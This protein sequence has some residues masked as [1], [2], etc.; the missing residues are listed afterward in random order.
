[1]T[2]KTENGELVASKL[3][4][5]VTP[6]LGDKKIENLAAPLTFHLPVD[7]SLSGNVYVY[8]E[9]EFM[10]VYEIVSEGGHNYIIVSSQTFSEFTVE[11]QKSDDKAV[12][13][14]TGE[15]FESVQAALNAAANGE[16]V[17]LVADATEA[18]VFISAGKTLDLNGYTL[19]ADLVAASFEGAA[20]IDS[21]NGKGLLKVEKDNLSLNEKNPQLPL[22]YA[23]GIRFVEASFAHKLT[24][25]VDKDGKEGNMAYYRFAF[26]QKELE[27]ILDDYLA[28]GIST[29]NIS[30]RVKASWKSTAG[31]VCQYFTFSDELVQAYMNGWDGLAFRLYLTGVA[32]LDITFTAE[33]VSAA[34]A[35]TT[36]IIPSATIS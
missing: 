3:V 7:D 16:T 28:T 9:G 15:I 19:T 1:M 13:T 21:T 34:S 17:K 26:E 29:N 32:G 18:V 25:Q 30:I 20:I 4:F 5:D 14:T 10:G 6:M 12:N 35:Q 24:Y 2:V 31:T 23:E 8:H 33:I 27:T 22:W 36:V 11:F